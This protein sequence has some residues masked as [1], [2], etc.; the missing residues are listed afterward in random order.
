MDIFLLVLRL[1]H[2]FGGIFWVGGSLMINFFIGPTIG[3]TAQA[4]KQFAGHLMMRTNLSMALTVSAILTVLAG[5][6]LYWRDSQG[7]T[8][9]WMSA[10]PG[11]GFGIGAVSALIGFVFGITLG[12]LNKKMALIGSQIKEG[13]PTP[14]QLVQMQK[15][16]DQLKVVSPINAGSLIIAVVFMAIARYLVF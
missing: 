8:S 14:E 5:G 7:F 12:Q 10:G 16:Q 9:L 1:V 2:V 6:F 3:A 13:G 4:G 15:I 11:V